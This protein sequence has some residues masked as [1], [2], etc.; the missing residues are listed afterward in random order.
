MKLRTIFY[1]IWYGEKFEEGYNYKKIYSTN[2]DLFEKLYEYWVNQGY[3]KFS[4]VKTS[5][6]T[7]YVWIRKKN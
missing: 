2:I 6:T 3:T 5:F 4:D 1:R 7:V